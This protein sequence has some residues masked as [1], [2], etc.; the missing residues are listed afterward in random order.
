MQLQDQVKLDWGDA[1]QLG[2]SDGSF[3]VCSMAFGIRNIPDKIKALKEMQRV[4]VPGGQVVILELT[5]PNQFFKKSCTA[6]I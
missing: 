1:T 4:I 3:D 5:T 6:F 2:F